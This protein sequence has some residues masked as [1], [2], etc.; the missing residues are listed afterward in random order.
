MKNTIQIQDFFNEFNS[1]I[2]FTFNDAFTFFQSR[3]P[4]VTRNAVIL[5]VNNLIK[6]GL[7]MRRSK[8]VFSF[9]KK[10]ELIM[11]V[12]VDLINTYEKLKSHFP[13][14]RF[15]LWNTR[16][17]NEFMLHQTGRFYNIIETEKDAT[18]FV[19]NFFKE[20]NLE[21][22][23]NPDEKTIRLYTAFAENCLIVKN[24][25]TE[26]PIRKTDSL[27]MPRLEKIL[28]D[29]F[30]EPVLFATQQGS[31]LENI[32]REAF[33]KYLVNT[34]SLYRYANRRNI[35]IELVEYLQS[36]NC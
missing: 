1:R 27:P 24:L 12:D 21:V 28:V 14:T 25:I 13:Y 23:L 35:K 16:V 19:F 33:N 7:L 26:A 5:R 17:F 8:G 15:C 22:F 34:K 29:A 6:K 10:N 32:F 2:H 3:E 36:I 20:N 31:E 4:N 18:E 11:Q 30:C 9:D